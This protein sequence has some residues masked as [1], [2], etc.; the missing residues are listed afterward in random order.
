MQGSIYTVGS[1]R[2]QY[3]IKPGILYLMHKDP[4]KINYTA[5]Q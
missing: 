2:S 1:F 5:G 3:L 4:I